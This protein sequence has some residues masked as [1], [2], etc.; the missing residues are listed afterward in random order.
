[1]TRQFDMDQRTKECIAR[2]SLLI[3]VL[4]QRYE[5]NTLDSTGH[6]DHRFAE[7][8]PTLQGIEPRC[9]N[10]PRNDAPERTVRD[11]HVTQPQ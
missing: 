11:A 6:V 4:E 1:M 8:S 5:Q 9:P 2:W 7:L 10:G 3:L